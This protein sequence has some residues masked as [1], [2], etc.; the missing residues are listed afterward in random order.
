MA[1]KLNIHLSS[2]KLHM[3]FGPIKLTTTDL[4]I[5]DGDY[6]VSPDLKSKKL[7]TAGKAMRNDL[8]VKEIP[9]WKVDNLSGSTI[10]I[11]GL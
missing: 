9:F 3:G 6:A 2:Q 1:Y 7:D 5:Y 10:I 11:G 8:I 4:P